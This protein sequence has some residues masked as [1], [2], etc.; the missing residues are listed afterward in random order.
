MFE[1]L[2]G[3]S[4]LAHSDEAMMAATQ[5]TPVELSDLF[6]LSEDVL[7]RR[8]RSGGMS[9][10]ERLQLARI[11]KVLEEAQRILG[12]RTRGLEWLKHPNRAL[13]FRTPLVLLGSQ[14]GTTRVLEA[15]GRMGGGGFA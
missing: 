3:A 11:A 15:L 8:R 14:K 9:R 7:A 2:D 13:S 5:L 4:G 1:H 10:A 12:D 6:G